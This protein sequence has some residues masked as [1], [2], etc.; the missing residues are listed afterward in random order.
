M[1]YWQS[2]TDATRT[3][4][5]SN[6]VPVRTFAENY[7]KG[8]G[9][10][11]QSAVLDA[12]R[13]LEGHDEESFFDYYQQMDPKQQAVVRTDD[14]LRVIVEKITR[15]RLGLTGGGGGDQFAKQVETVKSQAT[16]L[17]QAVS[18]FTEDGGGDIDGVTTAFGTF[19]N[20]VQALQ[21]MAEGKPAERA[22]V[23]LYS[24]GADAGTKTA[25]FKESP[26]A[27][28]LSEVKSAFANVAQAA[29]E[30]SAG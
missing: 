19:M 22:A 9:E 16:T 29:N 20:D 6:Y 12:R 28:T 21:K 23:S 13:F 11:T 17:A 8:G 15:S 3:M 7:F 18:S 25:L 14:D 2:L 1:D 26:S 30:V 10:S 5:G 24:A 27:E 4:I